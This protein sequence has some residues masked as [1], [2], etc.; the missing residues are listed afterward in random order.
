MGSPEKEAGTIFLD[1]AFPTLECTFF[2]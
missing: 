2:N 1:I